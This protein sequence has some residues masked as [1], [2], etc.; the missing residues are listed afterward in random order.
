MFNRLKN[1]LKQRLKRPQF[2]KR[3]RRYAKFARDVLHGLS[4]KRTILAFSI[5]LLTSLSV[6]FAVAIL[7]SGTD[8]IGRLI[9]ELAAIPAFR[10]SGTSDQ[11]EYLSRLSRED[12]RAMAS[13]VGYLSEVIHRNTKDSS[14][15]KKL[16]QTIVTQS[17]AAN[18][19]PLLVAAVIKY[20]STFNQAATSNRGARGL[21]Q[22]MP[23]TAEYLRQSQ[24][25]SAT[26]H[27]TSSTAGNLRVGI[28]YLKYLERKFNGNRELALIAYNWGPTNVNEAINNG[29]RFLQASVKYAR[30]ILSEQKRWQ[31][32]FAARAPEFQ[33]LEL[34]IATG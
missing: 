5:S 13:S 28:Q 1:H 21:M 17:M 22:V 4:A 19:D 20:E 7:R 15:N 26:T 29:K 6:I 18:Y 14:A 3:K 11:E 30:N 16:A 24:G 33:H 32:E 34:D 12:R 9:D 27:N 8:P 31:L 25:L 2:I 10:S 23:A